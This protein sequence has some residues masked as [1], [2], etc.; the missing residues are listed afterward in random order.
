METSTNQN[1]HA[2]SEGGLL[3]SASG[4]QHF[5]AFWFFNI[6]S[7]PG[8]YEKFPTLGKLK[9]FLQRQGRTGKRVLGLLLFEQELAKNRRS[10]ENREHRPRGRNIKCKDFLK[11]ENKHSQRLRVQWGD[12]GEEAGEDDKILRVLEDLYLKAMRKREQLGVS[13]EDCTL[14]PYYVLGILLTCSFLYVLVISFHWQDSSRK[15]VLHFADGGTEAW[16]G[17]ITC[18][19]SPSQYLPR[20]EFEPKLP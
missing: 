18:P 5:C 3:C 20:S 19:K 10:E 6:T 2:P 11:N 13:P 7:N 1:Q 8:F 14:S 17:P 9:P 15:Q 16:G 12:A 4:Y